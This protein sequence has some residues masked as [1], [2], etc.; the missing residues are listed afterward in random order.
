MITRAR[1]AVLL[2]PNLYSTP[3]GYVAIS[4]A[5]VVP[6]THGSYVFL[7]PSHARYLDSRSSFAH[8]VRY[9][10][11]RSVHS[12]DTA[13]RSN[14]VGAETQ[15]TPAL[16][17][18]HPWTRM[19]SPRALR[20]PDSS[21]TVTLDGDH[22]YNVAADNHGAPASAAILPEQYVVLKRGT[23]GSC[24][25]DHAAK[26]DADSIPVPEA[27]ANG[28]EDE[29]EDQLPKPGTTKQ[30]RGGVCNHPTYQRMVRTAVREISRRNKNDDGVHPEAV[31][32]FIERRWNIADKIGVREY[33]SQAIQK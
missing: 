29:Q 33:V 27:D 18:S 31:K 23:H 22:T 13:S 6:E 3:P 5:S 30:G 12:T 21:H 16:L 20:T 19:P 4:N 15:A 1:E 14:L 8:D 26:A 2:L 9:P 25:R 11:P 7:P 24:R 10:F 28:D 32:I 17:Q